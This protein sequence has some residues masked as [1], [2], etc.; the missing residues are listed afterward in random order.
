MLFKFVLKMTDKLV[1]L[2]HVIPKVPTVKNKT[3][4]E[5]FGIDLFT[6]TVAILFRGQTHQKLQ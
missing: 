2:W 1:W 3:V 5:W 6:A 4:N